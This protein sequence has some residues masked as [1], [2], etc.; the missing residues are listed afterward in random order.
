MRNRHVLTAA[1][2]ALVL[3]PLTATPAAAAPPGNDEPAGA[4]PIAVGDRVVQD[5]SEATTGASDAELNEECGAP[6]TN[7]SV[8]YT[9]TPERSG[10][11]VLDMSDSDYSGG[12]LVFEGA[13]SPETL[14]SCGAFTVPVEAEAGTAYTVMVISDTEVNGG[15]LVLTLARALRPR[16]QVTVARRGLAYRN[17]DARIRGRYTCRRAEEF[18]FVTASLVQRAGRLKIPASAD[19]GV[20]CDGQ[21]HRWSV[22]LVSRTGLYAKGTAQARVRIVACG[23]VECALDSSRRQVRLVRAGGPRKRSSATSSSL[24]GRA[25]LPGPALEISRRW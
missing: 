2:A 3:V 11:Y 8:W 15:E 10:V 20:R 17:G 7:A 14:V 5:T 22:R 9:F 13:P 12:A 19:R 23:F 1:A 4:V 21:W 24:Q 25:A 18:A 16:A 6:E